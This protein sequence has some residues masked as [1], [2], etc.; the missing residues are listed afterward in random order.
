MAD[1]LVSTSARPN[2]NIPTFLPLADAAKKL[3]MSRKLLTQMAETGKIEAVQLPSGELLVS[4]ENGQY[5]TKEEVI[6]EKYNH[7]QESW[8]TVTEAAK[9]YKVLGRTIREWIA[10]KYIEVNKNV[11]PMEV[12]QADVAY[13]ADIYHARKG[14]SGVPL[15]DENG[16]PYELKH[17]ELAEYR[18]RK[19]QRQ[20]KQQAN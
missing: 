12:N 4:A 3:G 15:L 9:E 10:A 2:P 16:L 18:Q 6:A 14:I 1:A 13:C 11:Y 5:K 20:R 17:P 19:R 8:I 7:L